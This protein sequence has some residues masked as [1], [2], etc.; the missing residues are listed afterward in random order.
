M[1]LKSQL[2][3]LISALPSTQEVRQR[4]A[5]MIFTEVDYLNI[6]ID[7]S[8]ANIFFFTELIE[9][10]SSEGQAALLKFLTKLVDSPFA[11]LEAK[12]K[13]EAL[14]SEISKLNSKQWYKEFIRNFEEQD[15]HSSK[16]KEPI[17][18]LPQLDILYFTGRDKELED[19]EKLLIKNNQKEKISSIVGLT[20]SGGIGKSTLAC[21]FAKK[22]Q[23]YF[24]DGVIGLRVDRKDVDTIAR[25]FVSELA[26]H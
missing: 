8:G 16:S 1:K 22:Y 2:L 12:T 7:F 3:S 10:L 24:P 19:L 26:R 25:G 21:H 11:S 6:K 20:G 4:K 23:N 15:K 14:I 9:L 18:I 17:F 5:L 13:F